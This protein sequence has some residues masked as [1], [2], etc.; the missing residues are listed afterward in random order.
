MILISMTFLFFNKL[1]RDKNPQKVSVYSVICKGLIS[2][3]ERLQKRPR[4]NKS[5][6]NASLSELRVFS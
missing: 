3:N 6:K 5:D 2:K 4:I 1:K